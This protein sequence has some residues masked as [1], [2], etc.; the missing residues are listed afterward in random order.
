MGSYKKIG[1][2]HEM[3]LIDTLPLIASFQLSIVFQNVIVLIELAKPCLNELELLSFLRYKD[4]KFIVLSDDYSILLDVRLF[5]FKTH[6][7]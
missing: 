4:T 1:L 7:V 3:G 6:T 2:S 5:L